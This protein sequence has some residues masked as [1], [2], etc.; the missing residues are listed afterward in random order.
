MTV[1]TATA[2]TIHKTLTA[3]SAD[4]VTLDDDYAEVEV[5][6]RG[7]SELYFTVDKGTAPTVGGDGTNVVMGGGALRVPS[8]LSRSGT[9]TLVRLIAADAVPYS[10]TGV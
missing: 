3:S 2:R 6:N 7:T 9:P 8:T 5:V 1:Y 10:V 4:V